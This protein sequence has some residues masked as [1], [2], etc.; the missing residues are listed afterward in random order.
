MIVSDTVPGSR[1]LFIVVLLLVLLVTAGLRLHR[2]P[3]LP[4]GLHYDEAANGILAGEIARGVKIPVFISS[5]TGKEVSFFY[6]AA[7][8]MKLLGVTPFALRLSAAL[9]GL[10]TVAVTVWSV[11]ELLRDQ[12]DPAWTGLITAA[13]L[14][15]SFWHLVLSRYGFRAVTQPLLQALTI[16]PLWRG[17][18][19]RGES[20]GGVAW[21]FL[22]GLACGLTAYTYLAARAFPVPLAAALLTF[23]VADRDRRGVHLIRL[24]IFV[25][26]AALVLA[27]LASHWLT[28]PGAFV[29]RTRQVAAES[30]V[31]VWRGISACLRMFFLRGDPYIRF[32]VPHRPLFAPA[33]AALFLLGLAVVIWRAKGSSSIT[34][35]STSAPLRLASYVFLLV[36]L[37]VMSLPSAL[38][39]G[40]ITPSNLRA[41]GLLPFIYVFP[42]LGLQVVLQ[43]IRRLSALRLRGPAV[44]PRFL[45]AASCLLLLIV[46]GFVG[47]STYLGWASSAKLYRA[48][49]GDLADVA[50]YLNRTDLTT[51]TP[52]VASVHYRHPTMA[53]LARDYEMIRWLTGGRTLVF[54]S[55][56]DALSIFP[57][58]TSGHLGWVESMLPEDA[59][60]AAPRGP[61]GAPAFHAYRVGAGDD[62]R[63]TRP[64]SADLGKVARLLGYDVVNEP[65]SGD[66]AEVAVWWR[67]VNPADQ[68]DY[69]PV[70][71]LSDHWGFVWGETQPFHY[72]SEQWTP[73]E[74]IVDYL[75]IPV[76]HG[77][78]PGDYAVRLGLY[79][80]GAD[81]RLPLLEDGAYVGTYIELPI[82]LTRAATPPD[83]KS[84]P[85]DT[86]L[87]ARID[88]LT[89]LGANLDTTKARP[90][91][92]IYL[93]LFWR[94]EKAP[95]SDHD[96]LI[97]LGH[98]TLYDDAPVH[99]TYPTGDWTAGE[100]VADRYGLRL[101]LDTEPGGYPL[102]LRV[103]NK[104]SHLGTV[105]VRSTDRAFEVPPISH[106]LSATLGDRV[107]L[108]GYDLAAESVTPGGRLTL[109]L[110]WR[111]L[112]EMTRD[113]T[114]F[115]HLL[116]PDGSM[117]GQKDDMP[118]RGT[119]ATSLWLPGEVVTDVYE[120]SVSPD[121]Q[122]DEHRLEV[123][124]YVAE[125][126]A[127]LPVE[128]SVDDAIALQTIAVTD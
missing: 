123:G 59:L 62:P 51:T 67:V 32:N 3:N 2:L 98:T 54:P 104:T 74:V 45:L 8:W 106:P 12:R 107:E 102:R 65:C 86:G 25:S 35:H 100:V 109:T 127:R 111:A 85:I 10:M 44:E 4:L 16:A 57:R 93:T 101:P 89:L 125:T 66:H 73:G 64:L 47:A 121:A 48:A 105:T 39:T 68:G 80:P 128:G 83:P 81:V 88:G 76:A 92:R 52:Y 115:T 11:Y 126:G 31:E 113:Y 33:T 72:P 84:L 41:V 77:A 37:P 63:P 82:H 19:H 36:S 50:A 53:F 122:P 30:W 55:E 49:D 69:G 26:A 103:A 5:Y 110:Y 14:A 71:R 13:F 61:D 29:T 60:V 56:G 34:I 78:P 22:A 46:S 87:D 114:V 43:T 97:D 7:L 23:L 38:A 28:H 116:S 119:Y 79:S 15:T 108:L 124:M 9:V 18:R 70:A 94:A 112:T 118:V 1:W 42:A 96:V 120:I 21:L 17:L 40:E 58:S 90:G 27:P 24:V 20:A 99:G 117:I 75:S 6:W 91:E 95:R